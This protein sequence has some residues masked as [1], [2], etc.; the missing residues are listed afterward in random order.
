MDGKRLFDAVCRLAAQH[1]FA[2]ACHPMITSTDKDI[3]VMAGDYRILVSQ[4]PQP[5]GL[6]GFRQALGM[7]FTGMI[8][9]N[10]RAAVEGHRANTFITIGKG[11]IGISADM[12]RSRFG[13]VLAETSAFTTSEDAARALQL[14]RDLTSLLIGGNPASAIHWCVGD[15]LVPQAFF[16]AAVEAGSLTPLNV[17]PFLASSAGRLGPGLP[18]GV[19]G[20]G[21]QWLVGKIVS[22][23]EAPVPLEWLLTT[24]YSFVDFC[25][26]RGSLIPHQDTFSFEGQEWVMGVFHQKIEGF[27]G[28]E[29]ARLKVL[30]YPKYGIYGKV[31]PKRPFDYKPVADVRSNREQLS[32]RDNKVQEAS[33]S[34]SGEMARLRNLARESAAKQAEAAKQPSGFASRLRSLLPGKPH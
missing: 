4:N 7:P 30:H 5:L 24:L 8:F 17:R 22:I 2:N 34:P 6:E 18:I 3:H 26:Q 23:E 21:S 32:G 31:P 9:P 20:N 10:A 33:A 28:W 14:C 13:D 27:N 11:P 12:L 19:T 1:G 16:D 29:M 15:N 25:V